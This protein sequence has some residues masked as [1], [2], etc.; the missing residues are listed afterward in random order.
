MAHVDPVYAKWWSATASGA[1]IHLDNDGS[2]F[3]SSFRDP[4]DYHPKDAAMRRTTV[5]ST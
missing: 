2:S 4:D 5:T 3:F 1:V